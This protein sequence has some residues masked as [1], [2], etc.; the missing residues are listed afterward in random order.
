MMPE[1]VIQNKKNLFIYIIYKYKMVEQKVHSENSEN[2]VEDFL[3]EDI[4]LN[5]QKYTCISFISP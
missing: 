4:P 1:E 5:G 3:D 2:V